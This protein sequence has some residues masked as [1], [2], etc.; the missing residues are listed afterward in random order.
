MLINILI[1]IWLHFMADFLL[2]SE[3][4]AMN[5]SKS[6]K[7][8]VYHCL[9]YSLPFLW[10]GWKFAII[11]GLLHFPI[12]F[13]SSRITSTIYEKKEVHWFFVVIGLDQAIHI[14]IL[15][16]TLNWLLTII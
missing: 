12:D 6:I 1:V 3:Y 2:Q 10:F 15:I 4:M 14:T 8:L 5:K 13:I 9:V 11:T 16:L 7:V